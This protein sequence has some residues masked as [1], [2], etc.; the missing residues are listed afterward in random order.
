MFERLGKYKRPALVLF[1]IWTSVGLIFGGVAFLAAV[2]ENRPGNHA[3]AV[4]SSLLST[5]AWGALSP[6]IYVVA[7]RYPIRPESIDRR[8]LAVNASL[9]LGVSLTYGLVL[10]AFSWYMNPASFQNVTSPLAIVQRLMLSSLYT[11]FSF[12][13]STFFT[14]Q[15]VLFFRNY[16]EEEAKNASLRAELSDARLSALKMQLHPHFLFNSLHSISSL[17][18]LDPR[19]A[20]TMVSLLGDFLRQTLEHSNDQTVTLSDEVEFLR[21]YLE[22]EKTRFEDRLTV[23]LEIDQRTL[24]ARVPHLIVQPLLEN[25][26][27]HGIAPHAGSGRIEVRSRISDGGDLVLRVSNS[28]AAGRAANGNGLGLANVRSRLRSIYGDAARLEITDWKTDGFQAEIT[29]PFSTNNEERN[30]KD[31]SY[32]VDRR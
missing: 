1:A 10:L 13:A 2:V 3:V 6:L 9:G 20:N 16:R 28:G 27:K 19:R 29:L 22:I 8:N 11:F 12:Y 23:D 21:C 26:I 25:A 17:I 5:Y 32:R 15:A 7:R 4:V 14:I 18:L 24:D 30:G 31:E